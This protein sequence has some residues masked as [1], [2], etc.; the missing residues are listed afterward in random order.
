MWICIRFDD[1]GAQRIEGHVEHRLRVEKSPPIGVLGGDEELLPR[2]EAL[3]ELADDRLGA[4]VRARRVD[5]RPAQLPHPLE[6]VAQRRHL[7]GGGDAVG[8]GAEADYRQPFTGR[9]DR[10]GDERQTGLRVS[11]VRMPKSESK[12]GS[13]A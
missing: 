6:D 12:R 10:F 11:G 7:F 8:V 5:D 1:V 2:A 4:A 13:C 3:E 9:G